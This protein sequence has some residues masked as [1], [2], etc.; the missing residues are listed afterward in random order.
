MNL[1]AMLAGAPRSDD[2]GAQAL[3]TISVHYTLLR[4][5]IAQLSGALLIFRNSTRFEPDA[6]AMLAKDA[7]KRS[8]EAIEA[9]GDAP[10]VIARACVSAAHSLQCASSRVQGGLTV[11]GGGLERAEAALPFL[12][13]AY[14]ELTEAAD[15]REG[16]TMIAFDGCCCCKPKP[17]VGMR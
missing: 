12:S 16:C 5:A 8:A 1:S 10:G 7:S 14:R 9:I 13:L 2:D 17:R 4:G 11:G 6:I 3:F 15:D